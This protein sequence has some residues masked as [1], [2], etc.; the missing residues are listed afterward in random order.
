VDL[1]ESAQG[2]DALEA[3]VK[4][5]LYGVRLVFHVVLDAFSGVYIGS[6]GAILE[7]PSSAL[8]GAPMILPRTRP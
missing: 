8:S 3:G 5:Q 2:R 4:R 6:A 1:E 7:A